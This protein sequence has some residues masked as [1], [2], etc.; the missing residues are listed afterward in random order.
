MIYIDDHHQQYF[1]SRRCGDVYRDSVSYLLGLTPETR[2]H[3]ADL[4]DDGNMKIEGLKKP[5]QTGTTTKLTR[6]AFN[7]WN[8]C[9]QDYDPESDEYI[10]SGRY[11]VDEIFCCSLAPYFVQAIQIRYPDYFMN[12]TT[13]EIKEALKAKFGTEEFEEGVKREKIKIEMARA[14]KARGDAED[15]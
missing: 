5:W 8:G 12:P 2:K 11:A 6:L 14:S 10:T 3:A 13:L 4:F 9:S 15:A 1:E 7:L